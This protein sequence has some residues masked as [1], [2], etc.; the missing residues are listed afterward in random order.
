MIRVSTRIAGLLMLTL[1]LAGC[2]KKVTRVSSNSTI[3]LSGRWNDTDSRLVAEEMLRDCLNSSW[4]YTYQAQKKTPTVIVG[5]VK[6]K[7]HEH[8]DAE[9]F[10]KDMERALINSGKVEFVAN[11]GER[12]QLRDEK[13]D[14][15][16]NASVETR[17]KAGEESGAELML[18][19][20]INSIVDQEGS[21]AVVF[22]QIN[23]E[24]VQIESGRKLWIGDKKIK[25]Y[26]TKN[27]TK[28]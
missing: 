11:K 12:E 26:V 14:Q 7:S 21:K 16:R 4:Y 27:S 1:V 13:A 19:G 24:L 8:I 3:D 9:T 28:F 20:S 5:S 10:T 15:G 18:I 22:Y 6:N 25:K 2:G 23:L 17:N